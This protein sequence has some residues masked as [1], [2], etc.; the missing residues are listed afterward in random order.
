M[1]GK[2]KGYP[3]WTDLNRVDVFLDEN[4]PPPAAC[5]SIVNAKQLGTYSTTL[6][7]MMSLTL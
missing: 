7:W 1:Q 5:P 6:E 4:S 2:I 3:L